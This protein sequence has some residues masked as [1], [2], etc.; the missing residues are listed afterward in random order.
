[1][2]T[3]SFWQIFIHLVWSTK[4]RKNI[5]KGDLEKT[6]HR[7]IRDA[8]REL[9]LVPICVNSAWNHTHSFFSWNP[10][11]SVDDAAEKLK[12]AAVE[13]WNDARANLPYETAELE[14]Q[15]GWSAFSVGP[16][17]VGFVKKYVVHQKDNHRS[18][19]TV[20]HLESLKG[21]CH[22]K[23]PTTKEETPE[24]RPRSKT[25]PPKS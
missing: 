24:N 12:A 2:A 25:T 20:D 3:H 19:K 17:Q 15:D 22:K 1:M 5:L 8:A 21:E 13:A 7:A 10:S 16:R 14:W 9:G 18:G 23:P 4:N 6:A 11:V